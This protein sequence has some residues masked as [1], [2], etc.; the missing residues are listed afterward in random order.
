MQAS[1][2][3]AHSSSLVI[4]GSDCLLDSLL[5]IQLYKLFLIC[6]HI[7]M[8]VEK[9]FIR[10]TLW[11][12]GPRSG[13]LFILTICHFKLLHTPPS[14][15][16]AHTVILKVLTNNKWIDKNSFKSHRHLRFH[17]FLTL[18]AQNER[19]AGSRVHTAHICAW[20]SYLLN[21]FRLN[22][23]WRVDVRCQTCVLFQSD[24]IPTYL[25]V[26]W[27]AGLNNFVKK[28]FSTQRTGTWYK[29]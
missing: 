15:Y 1:L 19:T 7:W 14:W 23:V 5:S 10:I 22:L 9:I 17:V 29:I 27:N 21:E 3:G 16:R 28:G 24:I 2:S 8:F 25:N 18:C 11:G 12:G 4:N 26:K 13:F 6:L 20:S